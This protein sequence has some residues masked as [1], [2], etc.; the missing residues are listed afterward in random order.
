MMY[1]EGEGTTAVEVLHPGIQPTVHRAKFNQSNI[2]RAT[3]TCGWLTEP[4]S[5]VNEWGCDIELPR[6]FFGRVTNPDIGYVCVGTIESFGG[7]FNVRGARVLE[8]DSSGFILA[9]AAPNESSAPHLFT[10]SG[11]QYGEPPLDAPSAPIY[12]ACES[13]I[14]VDGSEKKIWVDLW[15]SVDDSLPTDDHLTIVI[16]AGFFTR[17]ISLGAFED[18]TRIQLTFAMTSS[19][20]RLSVEVHNELDEG[21]LV[22]SQ[23]D[24]PV[25]IDDLLMQPEACDGL[26]TLQM[27]VG[28]GVLDG[29]PDIE[30][31]FVDSECSS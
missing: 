7:G 16:G 11:S 14:G 15:V 24:W 17:G 8:F 30:F 31:R 20:K 18:E 9:A 3:E 21:V 6:V 23:L 25:E 27:D 2:L 26:T 10:A 12:E 28:A 22:S 29:E 4:N 5:E 19:A 13:V 1:D